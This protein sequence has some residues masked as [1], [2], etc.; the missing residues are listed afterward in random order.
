MKGDLKVDEF[1]SRDLPHD[2][3]NEAFEL[4]HQ[5]KVI[6]SVLHYGDFKA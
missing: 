1:V 3:I 5:G 2:R 6:R 4:L